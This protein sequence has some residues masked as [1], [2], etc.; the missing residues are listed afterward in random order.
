MRF[1]VKIV[2]LFIIT[3]LFIPNTFAQQIPL[4]KKDVPPYIEEIETKGME[5]VFSVVEEIL[6]TKD[7]NI[8]LAT[9]RGLCN[10]NGI[11][12]TIYNENSHPDQF[13]YHSSNSLLEGDDSTL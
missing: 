12:F 3:I 6:Q 1:S 4:D 11:D 8:W 10:Y 9:N 13:L 2:T 7:G 5:H